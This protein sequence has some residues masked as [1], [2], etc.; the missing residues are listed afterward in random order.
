MGDVLTIEQWN[1][2]LYQ[3]MR[4][5]YWTLYRRGPTANFIPVQTDAAMIDLTWN[6]GPTQMLRSSALVALNRGD[7]KLR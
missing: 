2:G 5:N 6:I 4:D 1:A 7:I 3:I